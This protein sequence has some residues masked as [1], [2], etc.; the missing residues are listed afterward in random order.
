[1]R[2]GKLGTSAAALLYGGVE[3]APANHRRFQKQRLIATGRCHLAPPDSHFGHRLLWVV[4][5]GVLATTYLNLKASR[6]DLPSAAITKARLN[7]PFDRTDR[8]QINAF[9]V[10]DHGLYELAWR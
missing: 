7:Y 4:L 10:Q 8:G 1:M 3:A 9:T 2:G 5:R 6:A